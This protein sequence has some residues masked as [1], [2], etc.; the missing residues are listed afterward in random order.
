[1]A[2]QIMICHH[3]DSKMRGAMIAGSGNKIPKSLE[4]SARVRGLGR[5][6]QMK[7]PL[8]QSWPPW[9]PWVVHGLVASTSIASASRARYAWRSV[10]FS[11][12]VCASL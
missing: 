1:M 9:H 3:T 8:A 2:W 7:D 5:K 12:Y 11:I 6:R 10:L 4:T